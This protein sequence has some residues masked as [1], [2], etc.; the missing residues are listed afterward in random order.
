MGIE[1]DIQVCAS[2]ALAPLGGLLGY[3]YKNTYAHADKSIHQTENWIL[4]IFANEEGELKI[5][6]VP[7]PVFGCAVLDI[8]PI[9]HNSQFV[10]QYFANLTR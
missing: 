6:T 9:S 4:F 5:L 8:N 10:V 2:P 1:R 7:T 3:S